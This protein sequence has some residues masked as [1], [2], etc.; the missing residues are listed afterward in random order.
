MNFHYLGN[1]IFFQECFLYWTA[2]NKVETDTFKHL[3]EFVENVYDGEYFIK[4]INKNGLSHW[5]CDVIN[6]SAN[7]QNTF[8]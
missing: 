6:W 4:Q 7:D 5:T 1:L 3:S 2:Q 8:K